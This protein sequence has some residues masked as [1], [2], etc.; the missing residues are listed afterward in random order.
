MSE[1]TC[2]T[3]SCNTGRDIQTTTSNI[4]ST[5]YFVHV[6]RVPATPKYMEV[7]KLMGDEK[8]SHKNN[9]FQS[10]F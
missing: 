4:K 2:V 1:K 3:C 8:R 9:I 6:Y 10:S 7:K 5:V